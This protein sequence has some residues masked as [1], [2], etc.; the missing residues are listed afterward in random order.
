M[1]SFNNFSDAFK[2][3]KEVVKKGKALAIETIAE[4]VYKDSDKYTYRDTGAM[5]NSAT[6]HSN[7]KDGYVIQRGPYV[8]RRYYEGGKPGKGN[9]HAVIQW[10][11][12]TKQENLDKYKKQYGIAFNSAKK[13]G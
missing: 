7:F 8:R 1:K 4:E 13:G 10:F 3:T 2:W 9:I 5:Y 12:K 6:L 11:E